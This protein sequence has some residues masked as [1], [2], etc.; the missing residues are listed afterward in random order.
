MA[1]Y[2]KRAFSKTTEDNSEGEEELTQNDSAEELVENQLIDGELPEEQELQQTSTSSN[3]TISKSN[4][5]GSK[6]GRKGFWTEEDTSEL[7]DVICEND[8]YRKKLSF[9]NNKSAK[10]SHIYEKVIKD[11]QKRFEER[12][13]VFNF[14]VAQ[15]RT[16][17]KG[18][19]SACKKAAMTRRTAT[20]IDD[21]ISRKGYGSWFKQLLALVESRGSWNPDLGCEPSFKVFSC[22]TSSNEYDNSTYMPSTEGSSSSAESMELFVPTPPKKR[23]KKETATS[24]FKEAVASFN[25]FVSTDPTNAMMEFFK[26]ESDASRKHEME[27]TNMQMKM[28]Q[29]MFHSVTQPQCQ[30]YSPNHTLPVFPKQFQVVQN[31]DSNRCTSFGN[32]IGNVSTDNEPSWVELVNKSNDIDNY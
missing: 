24:L 17:F 29:E 6:Q 12:G 10:T 14:T 9:I 30:Q 26:Q 21:Y 13:D 16:K 31:Y 23:A 28:L 5:K 15:T 7:I 19:V 4:V 2:K 25:Q 27:M 11:V 1:A 3:I 8:Y 22:V 32:T 20:G 18:C